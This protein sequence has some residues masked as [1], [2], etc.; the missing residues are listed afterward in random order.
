MSMQVTIDENKILTE[1][2]ERDGSLHEQIKRK[3]E[4]QLIDNF[5]EKIESK[6]MKQS[7]YG[8]STKKI[9][10]SVLEDLKEKQTELVKEILKSFYS[11][12]RYKQK[13]LEI[14]KK[15]KEFIDEN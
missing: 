3:V 7:W 2:L 1:I 8:E 12:Y 5:V 13:D 4:Q 15:L 6:F 9:E 11:S 14:L 10:D